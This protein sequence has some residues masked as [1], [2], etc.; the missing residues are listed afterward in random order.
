MSLR[1]H[2]TLE[3]LFHLINR[4]FTKALVSHVFT[5]FLEDERQAEKPLDPTSC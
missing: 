3:Q 5:D 2:P 1:R 4:E